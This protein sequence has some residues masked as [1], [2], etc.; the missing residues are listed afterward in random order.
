MTT[1][2]EQLAETLEQAFRALT[3]LIEV[4]G[5]SRA[6]WRNLL[7]PARLWSEPPP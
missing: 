6:T 3:D 4:N 1:T 7:K 5:S 2:I